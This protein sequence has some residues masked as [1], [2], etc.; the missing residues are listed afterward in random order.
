MVSAPVYGDIKPHE[1]DNN[2]AFDAGGMKFETL[3]P[4]VRLRTTYEGGAVYLTDPKQMAD[5]GQAF[6]SNPHKRLSI[7]LVHEAVAPVYGSSGADRVIED[8]EKEFARA[9]Y[10]Q[11]MKVTGAVSI[12]GET[13]QVDAY[14]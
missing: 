7:D 5:P 1:I 3:E 2:D 10:E 9:H 13:V 6:R 4:L 14:G 12:D 11:H 8:P